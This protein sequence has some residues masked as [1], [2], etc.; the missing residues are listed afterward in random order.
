MSVLGCK[1]EEEP[2]QLADMEAFV[3]A[4]A[5]LTCQSV[6]ACCEREG[7]DFDATKCR[8]RII[9]TLPGK[10]EADS[11]SA[12]YDP[13]LAAACLAATKQRTTCG[14][15]DDSRGTLEACRH[16][17]H[18]ALAPGARCEISDE[19]QVG[20][21]Q[22]VQ[23]AS[24]GD[25]DG[26]DAVCVVFTHGPA[27]RGKLGDDCR[28]TCDG[29]CFVSSSPN[30]ARFTL[31]GGNVGCYRD[32]GLRCVGEGRCAELAKLGEE[33]ILDQECVEG[34]F[35]GGGSVPG[36]CTALFEN[37]ADCFAAPIGCKS[38]Y[39]DEETWQCSEPV[40]ATSECTD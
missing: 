6:D 16:V 35:C 40:F 22:S 25:D 21:G 2:P 31:Q 30:R 28:T 26:D 1:S 34:A 4:L 32:D 37:G 33:C 10:L 11:P 18:G 7:V 27:Q 15:V 13:K 20:A 5:D 36:V 8:E 24:D 3:A 14:E 23:C 12:T 9:A 39:C 29:D 19:C 17:L 38:G